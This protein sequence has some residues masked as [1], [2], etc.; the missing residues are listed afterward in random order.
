MI[1]STKTSLKFSNSIKL[2]LLRDLIADYNSVLKFF[3]DELWNLDEIPSLLPKT[4]T[5]K[6]VTNLSARLV[7]CA[8]KQAS[9][10]VRGTLQKQKQRLFII[11][12]F[13]SDG[14][15]KEAN[16]LQKIYDLVKFSKPDIKLIPM[17][18]DSRFIS[19]DLQNSTS[20]DGWIKLTSLGSKLKLNFPFKRTSHFN[21]LSILGTVKPSI[22]LS[23]KFITFIFDIESPERPNSGTVLGI[24]INWSVNQLNFTGVK[25]VKI[26]NIKNLRKGKTINRS[27]S[28][29]TYTDIFEKLKSKFEELNVLVTKINPTYTSQRCSSCGWTRKINRNG[30]IFRCTSCLNTMDADINGALNISFPLAG[31]TGQQRLTGANKAGFYWY[32][33]GQ[34]NI[35]PDV[36]KPN[37]IE[38]L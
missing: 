36:Q 7:Q 31:I 17:E 20:F 10:I 18:L 12:K 8:G 13:T 16:K 11:Q 26:E 2:N 23:E 29:W 9:G 30:K 19:I 38:L 22:R 35:V 5:S 1:R 15:L 25:E 21:K 3:I 27:L 4:I 32:L 37:F 14:K 33:K 6:V 34:E 28:H 24:D